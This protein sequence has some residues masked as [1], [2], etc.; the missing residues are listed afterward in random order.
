MKGEAK[1]CFISKSIMASRLKR[2]LRA[3]RKYLIICNT[4]ATD[5]W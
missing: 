3:R 4:Y 5:A 2:Q 1:L